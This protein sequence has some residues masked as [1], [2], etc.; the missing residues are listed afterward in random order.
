[1][2]VICDISEKICRI[3]N[4]YEII[5]MWMTANIHKHVMWMSANRLNGGGSPFGRGICIW[6]GYQITDG[7]MQLN[8]TTG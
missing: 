2:G 4:V 6:W 3:Y 1:M 7:R 8:I 5:T